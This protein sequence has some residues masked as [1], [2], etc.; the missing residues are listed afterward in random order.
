L[1]EAYE[2]PLNAL[3]GSS[4]LES[5]LNFLFAGAKWDLFDD[6]GALKDLLVVVVLVNSGWNVVLGGFIFCQISAGFCCEDSFEKIGISFRG[7]NVVE[8]SNW[9]EDLS[10]QLVFFW[11]VLGGNILELDPEKVAGG[12]FNL[13][14]GPSWVQGC[15]LQGLW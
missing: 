15:L 11:K 7:Y 14:W 6:D 13:D 8:A 1:P 10:D 3:N 2:G 4:S 5:C 9:C 12:W